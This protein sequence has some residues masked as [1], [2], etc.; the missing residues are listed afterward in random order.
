MKA[1]LNDTGFMEGIKILLG[2]NANDVKELIPKL[3][4]NSL[5]NLAAAITNSNKNEALQI[6]KQG[7]EKAMSESKVRKLKPTK[8]R[9]KLI[10]LGHL[11]VGSSVKVNG[12]NATI[13]IPNGPGN[14]VGIMINGKL[15]MVNREKIK[16]NVIGM[17]GIPDIRRMQELAGILTPPEETIINQTSNPISDISQEIDISV[18][19]E[20]ECF[21]MLDQI[22]KM[23][24]DMKLADIKILRQKINNITMKMN[25]TL[26]IKKIKI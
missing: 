15:E 22:E 18:V 24:P 13:K 20:P 8:I 12:K 16:E 25:E 5:I 19:K 23:L 6:I 21:E 14:T 4:S 9:K 2:M 26:G 11:N 3:D 1:D 7:R 17:T 10:Q